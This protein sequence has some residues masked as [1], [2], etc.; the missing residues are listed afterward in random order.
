MQRAPVARKDG[1]RERHHFEIINEPG[2]LETF[3]STRGSSNID[4]TALRVPVRSPWEVTGWRVEDGATSSDHRAIL[5]EPCRSRG[6]GSFEG[7]REEDPLESPFETKR[8]RL[9]TA[10]WD[11]FRAIVESRG[12]G[13]AP[14]SSSLF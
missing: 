2:N 12:E 13:W 3:F 8:Y 1:R 9:G 6:D 14:A 4:V 11:L 10:N 5:F 7:G